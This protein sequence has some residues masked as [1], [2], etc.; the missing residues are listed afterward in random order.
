MLNV[1]YHI[2]I[3]FFF[4]FYLIHHYDDYIIVYIWFLLAFLYFAKMSPITVRSFR[5]L[6]LIYET[7]LRPTMLIYNFHKSTH[8]KSNQKMHQPI[9]TYF[10]LNS[11]RTV[12]EFPK[13][14]LSKSFTLIIYTKKTFVLCLKHSK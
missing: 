6:I 11:V 2:G 9:F 8:L 5:F 13:G 7:S 4:Y 3:F 1:F 12:S 10:R 14:R